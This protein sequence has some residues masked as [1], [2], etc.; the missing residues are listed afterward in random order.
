MSLLGRSQLTKMTPRSLLVTGD[1]P[2]TRSKSASKPTPDGVYLK[3]S[4]DL[5]YHSTLL[6]NIMGM[7]ILIL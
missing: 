6:L 7:H 5:V 3:L 4:V 1:T 2:R